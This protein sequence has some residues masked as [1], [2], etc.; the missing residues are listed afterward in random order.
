MNEK[1]VIPKIRFEGAES[2]NAL[3]FHYYDANRV[4]LGKPMKDH[5]KFAMSW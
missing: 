3:A 2:K 4:I 1:I 5:L